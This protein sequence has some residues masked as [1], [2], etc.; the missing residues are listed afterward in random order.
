MKLEIALRV[1]ILVIGYVTSA[2]QSDDDLT[3]DD[4]NIFATIGKILKFYN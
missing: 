1:F 2:H 4:L 3:K